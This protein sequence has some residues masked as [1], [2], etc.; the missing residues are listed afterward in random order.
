MNWRLEIRPEVEADVAEA[1][2][3]NKHWRRR[4]GD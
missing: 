4:T 3:S 1:A 2:R